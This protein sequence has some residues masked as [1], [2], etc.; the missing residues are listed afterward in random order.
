MIRTSILAVLMFTAGIAFGGSI[1]C[2]FSNGWDIR[3]TG[4]D[5]AHEQIEKLYQGVSE[6]LEVEVGYQRLSEEEINEIVQKRLNDEIGD[7]NTPGSGYS[8]P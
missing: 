2:E 8:C 1:K 4:S 6:L 7:C 5:L 3:Y